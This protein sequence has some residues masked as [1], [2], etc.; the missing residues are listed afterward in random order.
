MSDFRNFPGA[1]ITDTLQ[2]F[3]ALIAAVTR[4]DSAAGV[5]E[6]TSGL[7]ILI[8]DFIRL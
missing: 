6:F 7:F 1:S 8:F 3:V 4:T 2:P 5:G